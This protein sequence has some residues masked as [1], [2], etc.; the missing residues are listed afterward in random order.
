MN[1]YLFA[2]Y[3]VWYEVDLRM[4]FAVLISRI[5]VN[6]SRRLHQEHVCIFFIYAKQN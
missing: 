3:V 1:L 4:V 5:Y 2:G 6:E